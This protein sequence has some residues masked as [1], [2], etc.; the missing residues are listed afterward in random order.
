MHIIPREI[1][2]EQAPTAQNIRAILWR[3]HFGRLRISGHC[4][5]IK[6]RLQTQIRIAKIWQHKPIASNLMKIVIIACLF[7]VVNCVWVHHSCP[8]PIIAS[9][10]RKSMRVNKSADFTSSHFSCVFGSSDS[11][12]MRSTCARWS[13]GCPLHIV[14]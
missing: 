3:S 14:R 6:A 10:V 11:V 2:N 7:F 8:S 12:H 1:T 13:A 4:H 5:S 9:F